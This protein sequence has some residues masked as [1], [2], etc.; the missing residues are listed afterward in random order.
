MAALQRCIGACP[1]WPG[2]SKY[3]Y[4]GAETLAGEINWDQYFCSDGLVKTPTIWNNGLSAWGKGTGS[5]ITFESELDGNGGT[6]G[7]IENW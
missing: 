5:C 2:G 1:T 4:A 3:K 6:N 7:K